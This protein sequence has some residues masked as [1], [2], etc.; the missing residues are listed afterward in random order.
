MVLS[1]T[2]C[3]YCLRETLKDIKTAPRGPEDMSQERDPSGKIWGAIP[4]TWRGPWVVRDPAM[5]PVPDGIFQ[6]KEEAERAIAGRKGYTIGPHWAFAA[7]NPY[8]S[9]IHQAAPQGYLGTNMQYQAKRILGIQDTEVTPS[10]VSAF[11]QW[12]ESIQT[13][14]AAENSGYD[15][16]W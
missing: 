2:I 13:P 11:K 1:S 4:F 5:R 8:V 12:Q 3:L 9:P 14:S 16:N 7:A 6:R 15:D 10:I